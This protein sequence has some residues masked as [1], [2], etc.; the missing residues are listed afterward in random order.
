MALSFS[1][2]SIGMNGSFVVSVSLYFLGCGH[3]TW[4]AL[5]SRFFLDFWLA[6]HKWCHLDMRLA[7]HQWF[8][9]DDGSLFIKGSIGRVGSLLYRG[10]LSLLR[11]AR[12]V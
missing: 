8:C 9:P 5:I 11:L 4:L 1:D 12:A 3:E 7:P 10:P 6:L 2:G